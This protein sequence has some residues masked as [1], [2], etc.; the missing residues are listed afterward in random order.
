M[1]RALIFDFDGLIIDTE[2]C[3]YE[4]WQEIYQSYGCE[5]PFALWRL[6]VGRGA[7]HGFDPYTH[8]E[9]KSGRALDHAMIRQQR[10][11]RVHELIAL[12]PILPGVVQTLQDAKRLGLKLAVASSSSAAWVVGHLSRV[13]LVEYFDA[14]ITSDEVPHAKPQPHLFLAAL[15]LLGVSPD[16]AVVLEDSANGITAANRAG[17]FVVA[18]PNPITAQMQLDHADLRLPSL[19]EIPLEALLTRVEASRKGQKG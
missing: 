1:I 17:I 9:E 18:I 13:G 2:A 3:E 12:R 4:T 11:R 14:I 8:L 19:A 10:D 7:G 16:E 6:G 15:N 5:L